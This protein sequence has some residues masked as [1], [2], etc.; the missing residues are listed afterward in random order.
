M[1]HE[2]EGARNL[3]VGGFYL[4]SKVE[5]VD[6]LAWWRVHLNPQGKVRR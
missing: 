1:I 5:Q 2:I 6:L 3:Q 4:L